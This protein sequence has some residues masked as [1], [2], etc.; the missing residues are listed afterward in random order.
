MT[1]AKRQVAKERAA[2]GIC[3]LCDN[4]ILPKGKRGLCGL[5]Y[6][7]M[8]R[9]KNKAIA[10]VKEAAIREAIEMGLEDLQYREHVQKAVDAESKAFEVALVEAGLLA[11]HQQKKKKDPSE[12]DLFLEQYEAERAKKA[13][14]K[15]ARKTRKKTS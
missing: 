12:F 14:K 15:P 4:K 6:E 10:P 11:E 8:R 5:H 2:K 1:A 13:T 3:I 9:R 7:A